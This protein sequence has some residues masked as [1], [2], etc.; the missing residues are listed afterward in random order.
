MPLPDA[1]CDPATQLHG[2][3]LHGDYHVNL[4]ADAANVTGSVRSAQQTTAWMNTLSNRSTYSK[5]SSSGNL[6]LAFIYFRLY[7]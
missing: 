5:K 2:T 1:H 7:L 3:T 4:A 6:I